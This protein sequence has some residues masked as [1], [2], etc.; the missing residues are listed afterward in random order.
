MVESVARKIVKEGMKTWIVTTE[1]LPAGLAQLRE[2]LDDV[3]VE[4]RH[5]YEHQAD[6]EADRRSDPVPNTEAIATKPKV[7]RSKSSRP[8]TRRERKTTVAI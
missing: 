1:R 6:S 4:A 5:E 7:S 2:E 3:L 8:A